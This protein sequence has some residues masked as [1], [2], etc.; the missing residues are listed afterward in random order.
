MF[1]FSEWVVNGI[2]DGYKSGLTSFAKVTELTANYLIK[3]I[4][5]QEQADSIAMI[6]PAP[7]NVNDEAQTESNGEEDIL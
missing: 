5:T 4:I 2:I 6:C 7:L 1:N 3:G